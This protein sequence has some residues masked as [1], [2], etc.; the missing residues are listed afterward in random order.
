M[1]ALDIN[2]NPID[3][4]IQIEPPASLLSVSGVGIHKVILIGSSSTAFD[5]L[6]FNSVVLVPEP[7]SLMLALVALAA[8][9][10][11]RVRRR[12]KNP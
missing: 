8:I 6:S 5:N 12:S 10:G 9:A 7:S 4:D 11:A 2:G 3:Y 1:I